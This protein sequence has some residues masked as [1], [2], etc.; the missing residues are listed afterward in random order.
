VVWK[1]GAFVGESGWHGETGWYR[2]N[3]QKHPTPNT[4]QWPFAGRNSA[5]TQHICQ[6]VG[7]LLIACC[8]GMCGTGNIVSDTNQ[9]KQ[10]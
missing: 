8:P 5:N 2:N 3:L 10:V 4:A 6:Q 1:L 9:V 7:C